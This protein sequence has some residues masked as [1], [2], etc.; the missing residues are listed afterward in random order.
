MRC[1]TLTRNSFW[2]WIKITVLPL[3]LVY[4]IV[5]QWFNRWNT[6]Y[7]RICI[8]MIYGTISDNVLEQEKM[9]WFTAHI[10]VYIAYGYATGPIVVCMMS[11]K[12][13]AHNMLCQTEW[14]LCFKARVW[15]CMN[16]LTD[17]DSLL[18][19]SHVQRATQTEV[20][21]TCSVI[22]CPLYRA[23]KKKVNGPEGAKYFS[24][25]GEVSFL[26]IIGGN[27]SQIPGR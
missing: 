6:D 18:P 20:E 13:R 2:C 16:P 9:K 7:S 14:W 17:M 1:A 25:L 24:L 8:C 27:Y 15:L 26:N 21:C 10:Q 12:G 4:Q 11:A 19:I 3:A 23:Q 5:F 22:E